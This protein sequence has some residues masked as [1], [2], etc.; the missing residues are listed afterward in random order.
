MLPALS[1]LSLQDD[2]G[3]DTGMKTWEL[4]RFKK[5][6][7]E[8]QKGAVKAAKSFLKEKGK[9]AKDAQKVQKEEAKAALAQLK[10]DESELTTPE[11]DQKFSREMFKEKEMSSADALKEIADEFPRVYG[12]LV[13]DAAFSKADIEAGVHQQQLESLQLDVVR[14]TEIMQ[15]IKKMSEEYREARKAGKTERMSDEV[16]QQMAEE[17]KAAKDAK[18]EA[19]EKIPVVNAQIAASLLYVHNTVMPKVTGEQVFAEQVLALEA[20]RFPDKPKS[21]LKGGKI[22][23]LVRT[24]WNS[25]SKEEK[26]KYEES[27][28]AKNEAMFPSELMKS[29]GKSSLELWKQLSMYYGVYEVDAL[30]QRLALDIE[31]KYNRPVEM[32]M[33]VSDNWMKNSDFRK[34]LKETFSGASVTAVGK[35]MMLRIR[36]HNK[37]GGKNVLAGLALHIVA[38]K[39]DAKLADYRIEFSGDAS[40]S[41]PMAMGFVDDDDDEVLNDVFGD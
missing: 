8:R 19:M 1:A 18:N 37:N 3:E 22:P 39:L 26:K 34:W 23:E 35:G 2:D 36:S 32:T 24:Q 14:N 16:K 12:K 6:L 38:A 4:Q 7:K 33:M 13:I 28:S 41:D 25:L 11:W 29:R 20:Q 15:R 10:K 5:Q 21:T 30:Y 17:H 31:V 9:E 27:A 40:Q